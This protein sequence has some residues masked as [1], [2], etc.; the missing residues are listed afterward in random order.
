[1]PLDIP[2]TPLVKSQLEAAVGKLE[3]ETAEGRLQSLLAELEAAGL[4]PWTRIHL[5]LGFGD[6]E[7]WLGYPYPD[8]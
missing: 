2:A 4:D 6:R 8:W 1:M 5:A 7:P 3:R